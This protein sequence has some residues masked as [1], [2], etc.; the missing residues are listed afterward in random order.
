GDQPPELQ[1]LG[2]SLFVNDEALLAAA[3]S[4][5]IQVHV[6][7][8]DLQQQA[9]N[10]LLAHNKPVG[11]VVHVEDDTQV[12][13]VP[14]GY[15]KL[16]I[17]EA[18]GEDIVFHGQMHNPGD[19][20]LVE[21][22]YKL[23]AIAGVNNPAPAVITW[24]LRYKIKNY[25]FI[26]RS[27]QMSL[28][29]EIVAR[30][31]AGID[32]D[33]PTML[34]DE[35]KLAVRSL[36]YYESL[37]QALALATPDNPCEPSEFE[38]TLEHIRV[39]SLVITPTRL[40]KQLA[41]YFSFKPVLRN[42]LM[43]PHFFQN[44]R[45]VIPVIGDIKPAEIDP[46]VDEE[47]TA[48]VMTDMA[49]QLLELSGNLE[50]LRAKHARPGIRTEAETIA[51]TKALVATIA[52]HLSIED[53]DDNTDIDDQQERL[54]QKLETMNAEAQSL[55]QQLK[56]MSIQLDQEDIYTDIRKG[57]LAQVL[58]IDPNDKTALSDRSAV[59]SAVYH[60]LI[61]LKFLDTYV[62]YIRTGHSEVMPE[63][64]ETLSDV[65]KALQMKAPDENDDVYLR[66]Q[67][68][69]EELQEFI[70]KARQ[71][72][73]KKA[74]DILKDIEGILDIKVNEEDDKTTRLIRVRRMFDGD[75]LTDH[76][77]DKIDNTLWADENAALVGK[78]LKLARLL[79]HLHYKVGGPE[80]DKQDREQQTDPL[81][82][83]EETLNIA[84]GK[85]K[86]RAARLAMVLKIM[87]HNDA[88]EYLLGEIEQALWKEDSKTL[89][90]RGL[91]LRKLD[92]SLTY[93][94]EEPYHDQQVRKRQTRLIAAVEH[95]LNIHPLDYVA[96]V[97]K[98]K[99][100]TAKLASDLMM[101]FDEGAS[102]SDRKDALITRIQAFR[103]EVNEV[104]ED[105]TVRRARNNEIAR[106]LNM[107]DY[108]DDATIN[109]QNSRIKA[110]LQQLDEEVINTIQSDV[111][112]RITVIEN[113]LDRHMTRLGPK[114]RYVLDRE[115]T[116]ARQALEKAES[117]LVTAYRKNREQPR[118]EAAIEARK[119]DI[120]RMKYVLK[121]AEQAV[122]NDDGP[123]QYTPRQVKV[124]TDMHDFIY[125]HAL[126]KQALEAAM[127]LAASAAKSG[128]V[129]PL[130]STFDFDDEFAPIRLQAAVGKD[131]T[132][133]QAS[134]IARVFRNLMR[135][136]P[137]HSS[138]LVDDQPQSI[139]EEVQIL[140]QRV[141]NEMGKGAL[142]Y[143]E[144]I[145]GMGK[146]AIHFVKYEEDDLKSF[147]EYLATRSASGNKII[148][149]L[150]EGLIS[151]VE[152][153]NYIKAVRG[154][155]GYQT[156][157]EFEH[158][159][160]YIHGVKVP[161][162]RKVVQMLSDEGAEQF[163][164]I[165]FAPVT[166][167]ATGPAGMKE[168]VAG[169]KEF[170]A[171]I[172]ANYVLD[173]IAFEN[174]RRTAAFLANVQDTLAPYAN[175]A[176]LS[177]SDLIQAIHDTLMQVHAEAVE[178]QLHD[179]WIKPSAFLVQAVTWYYSSYKPL[180]V[181]R[182]ALEAAKTSLS[183]IAFL[184]LLDLT[185][186]G[187]YTHRMLTPFQ[188]WL[189]RFGVDLDRTD[190][191]AYHSGIEKISEVGG[192][193]MPLGK[194]ASSVILLRTGSMLFARQCHANP[195]MYRSI[196]RLV[197]EIVKSMGSGQ[198]VQIPL[199]HRITPEKVKTLAS[200]TAGLVLGPV[201]TA[202]AY[203]QGLISGFTYAQTFGF[204]LASS[205]TFDFFM[206]DNKM[207]TQWL[208]GPLGRSLDKINRWRGTGETEADYVKRT[209]I[210]TPQRFNETNEEYANRVKADNVMF[211]WTRNEHY[212]QFRERRDQTM[213]MYK[214][215]WEKYFRDNVPK[216]SF[217]HTESIPYSYTLG[218]FFE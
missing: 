71:R 162:F 154:V 175:A 98:V 26:I 168:S 161:E 97:Q 63:V 15:P 23:W 114:P 126:K 54:I 167:T 34:S 138:E 111:N 11:Y 158:F 32:K 33:Q 52:A 18:P 7:E 66:R 163:M 110:K 25:E 128:K 124:L 85:R 17:T 144:V 117:E 183:N 210:A 47:F 120:E 12:Y 88:G 5:Y 172:I 60:K 139:L 174:G 171:A 4:A 131:L 96:A 44:I 94:V 43:N 156:V 2:Q 160:G 207:L 1:R 116:T 19:V 109:D 41:K 93:K 64:L 121:A 155:D 76:M 83:V 133:H 36:A 184:Y 165:A 38:F 31:D 127:G 82:E 211:G 61:K 129:P 178:R 216:W 206:N 159:L 28:L 185:N 148:A 84:Y 177:E 205:L 166:V 57:V 51:A 99:A 169:M 87:N 74:L 72:S 108:K 40:H 50:E 149:L 180:L 35:D 203:A 186:R 176:G 89:D 45:K 153:E 135:S 42:L 21:N 122:E 90:E 101:N 95:Q 152:L 6:L 194:A 80:P 68:I 157:A 16:E 58:G 9:L 141:R 147:L 182:T 164:R 55:R 115:A 140:V 14:A 181:T 92:A 125:Q 106:Q 150:H 75:D 134:R 188:H 69:S 200:A 48:R 143:D 212:Q 217:S 8:E 118:L 67:S 196:F 24:L 179:Y 189:E 104:Y 195:Q 103:D 39:A 27:R 105:E 199:L 102:L 59:E 204:A 130:L 170:A 187:D 62:D 10:E 46:G 215:G 151:K 193:A 53:F 70:A 136:F 142:Q 132:F 123:F 146:I 201:A 78:G 13:P 214:H 192:L 190:Q 209:A 145:N 73:E 79:A 107:E 213:K 191:Y 173:D 91:R 202:G 100:F 56:T 22:L 218:T 86:D 49:R 77:L 65:E 198:G 30:H 81:A 112:T 3:A 208:G 113:E 197:P 29:E 37:Q 119:A 20:A 137:P